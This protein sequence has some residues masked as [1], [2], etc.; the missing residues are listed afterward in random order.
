MTVGVHDC[1]LIGY[2]MHVIAVIPAD[3]LWLQ[4]YAVGGTCACMVIKECFVVSCSG[5][6]L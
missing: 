3:V 2:K 6:Q 4:C 5:S 1:Q